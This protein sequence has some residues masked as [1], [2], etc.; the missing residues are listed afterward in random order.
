MIAWKKLMD[1]PRFYREAERFM[2]ARRKKSQTGR[3]LRYMAVAEDASDADED[4]SPFD[5]EVP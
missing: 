2:A 5:A 3:R 4:E 1:Q